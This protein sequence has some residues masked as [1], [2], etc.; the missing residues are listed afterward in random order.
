MVFEI[1]MWNV[2]IC[3]LRGTERE[4]GVGKWY[5]RSKL[6]STTTKKKQIKFEINGVENDKIII[7]Y[8]IKFSH[9][10]LNKSN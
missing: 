10:S 2:I 6:D 4:G 3:I 1:V 7:E 8:Q 9:F 5:R